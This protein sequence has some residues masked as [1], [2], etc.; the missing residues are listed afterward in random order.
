MKNLH[1]HDKVGIWSS[2]LCTVH[3]LA[4]PV[5]MSFSREIDLHH[6]T[7]WNALQIL[8]VAISFWA[9]RHAASH[10][11]SKVLKFFF[12]LSFAALAISIFDHHSVIGEILN[13]SAATAL[14]VL[15]SINIYV[16]KQKQVRIA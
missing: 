5:V 10:C 1:W 8:F 11:S 16:Q 7:F 4:V 3:C 2:V 6:S 14:I 12:W 15:H 9:V 13:Y